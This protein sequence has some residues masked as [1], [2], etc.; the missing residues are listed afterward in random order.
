MDLIV[1]KD[2]KLELKRW[3]HNKIKEEG[4]FVVNEVPKNEVL[5]YLWLD[6]TL[7]ESFTL[8]D[9]FKLIIEYPL[10]QELDK[11]FPFY[12]E[13]YKSAPLNGCT[14]DEISKI[15]LECNVASEYFD[16]LGEELQIYLNVSGVSDKDR[17]IRYGIDFC[18][19]STILDTPIALENAL[20]YRYKDC[21]KADLQYK[22]K[23]KY[24]LFNLVH[25]LIYELSFYGTP[26]ERDKRG[27]E[28]DEEVE[29]LK[30]KSNKNK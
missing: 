1:K 27:K 12:I 15:I 9:Y 26:E 24:S 17:E 18:P 30:E 4:E 28:L 22:P 7:E 14:D 11:Y 5:S 2:G 16:T 19:L 3:K 23:F 13:E 29:G 20:L 25:G 10:L 6:I 8:R 21:N